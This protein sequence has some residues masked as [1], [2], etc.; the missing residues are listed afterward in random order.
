[1][2]VSGATK[3]GKTEWVKKLHA[4]EPEYDSQ[5]MFHAD[6]LVVEPDLELRH[7]PS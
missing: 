2:I 3:S 5:E 1:M 4:M 6:S 7:F